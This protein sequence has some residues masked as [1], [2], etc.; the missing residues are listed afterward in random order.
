MAR[1]A[2]TLFLANDEEDYGWSETYYVDEGSFTS[3][4][5][6]ASSLV[7]DRLGVLVADHQLLAYRVSEEG[8]RGDSVVKKRSPNIGLINATM[9]PHVD[10][11]SALMVRMEATAAKRGRKF[12]HGVPEDFF[13]ANDEYDDTN[14]SDAA[15]V[16]FTDRI[17]AAPYVL[18]G[19]PPDA[20]TYTT[21]TGAIAQRKVSHQI[22]R[23]FGSRRGRRSP[24]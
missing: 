16:T 24:A 12:L 1:Y 9:H 22:G 11:W 3:A 6:E 19:G 17:S 15:V 14:A 10:R 20:H 7:T 23:P 8:V 18:R 21:M 2:I 13:L 4:L 5:T